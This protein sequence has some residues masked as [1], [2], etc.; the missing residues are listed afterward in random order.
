M[1]LNPS[2]VKEF[3]EKL[4]QTNRIEPN[5][6]TRGENVYDENNI[7]VQII[8]DEEFNVRNIEKVQSAVMYSI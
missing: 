1:Q 3:E 5:L 6:L 2:E 4:D 8:N 7:N